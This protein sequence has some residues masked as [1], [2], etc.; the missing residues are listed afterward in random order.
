M[1]HLSAATLHNVETGRPGEDGLRRRN[2][3]VDEWLVLAAALDVAPVHLLIPI[4]DDLAPYAVTP[5][6]TV[7]TGRAR[8]WIRG[9]FPLP[10]TDERLYFSEVPRFE[11]IPPGAPSDA[12]E[13]RAFLWE[14]QQQYERDQ[15]AADESD[16]D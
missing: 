9:L 13:R 11:W 6:A 4:E 8:A 7:G 5:E 14:L 16:A 2:I 12:E 3:T 1:P 10:S 15:A